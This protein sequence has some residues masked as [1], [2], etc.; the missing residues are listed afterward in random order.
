MGIV[1]AVW[2]RNLTAS[3]KSKNIPHLNNPTT[4]TLNTTTVRKDKSF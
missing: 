2:K 3:I 4:G 1:T